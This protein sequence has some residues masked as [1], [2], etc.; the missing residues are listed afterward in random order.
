M[1]CLLA[2]RREQAFLRNEGEW[3]DMLDFPCQAQGSF[4]LHPGPECGGGRELAGLSAFSMKEG[5]YLDNCLF[6]GLFFRTFC[7]VD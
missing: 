3:D 1:L 5:G 7:L 4:I 2:I 6:C